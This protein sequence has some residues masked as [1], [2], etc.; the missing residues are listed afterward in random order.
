VQVVAFDEQDAA[1]EFRALGHL[2]DLA[3]DLLA[4]LVGRVRLA[5]EQEEHRPAGLRDDLGQ[6]FRVLEEQR[7]A[8]VG[9]EAAG[10]TDGQD[11]RV[12]GIGELEQAVEVG[13]RALVAQVLFA[14]A[15]ADQLQQLRLQLL[16]D[17]P[18]G[19]VGNAV[20]MP[21]QLAGSVWRSR[22]PVPR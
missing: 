14:D 22:Q 1:F 16:A 3:D 2:G 18:E 19:L 15:V 8:L 20:A 4:G 6:P 21:S 5:G 17:A 9:G 11:V 13:R 10:E 7:G 12:F